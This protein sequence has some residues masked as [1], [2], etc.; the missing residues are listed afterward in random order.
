MELTPDERDGITELGNI[1]TGKASVYLAELVGDDVDLDVPYVEIV[2]FSDAVNAL[3]DAVIQE[4][5]HVNAYL[6]TEG[7]HGNIVLDFPSDSV[8]PFLSRV[9]GSEFDTLDEEGRQRLHEVGMGVAERFL[10]AIDQFLSLDLGIG[11]GQVSSEHPTSLLR[12]LATAEDGDSEALLIATPFTIAPDIRGQLLLLITA[13]DAEE[14]VD[15]LDAM[16]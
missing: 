14:L 2:S 4:E 9:D 12:R 10:Q 6:S 16:M 3:P 7:V 5:R 11:E 13:D 15:A 8:C 1:G